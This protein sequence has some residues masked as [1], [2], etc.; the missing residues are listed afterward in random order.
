MARMTSANMPRPSA[1]E[2]GRECPGGR[3]RR[4]RVFTRAAPRLRGE[5]GWGC[6]AGDSVCSRTA[7]ERRTRYRSRSVSRVCGS[8][9]TW[10]TLLNVHVVSPSSS[11][12]LPDVRRPVPADAQFRSPEA[13]P[14]RCTRILRPLILGAKYLGYGQCGL[15]IEFD[16][17]SFR[18]KRQ[19][20][21]GAILLVQTVGCHGLSGNMIE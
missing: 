3:G 20:R 11:P 19:G 8:P 10:F 12:S 21:N 9:V 4:R 6:G 14:P 17:L 18:Q 5:G 1:R 2:S 7:Y 13:A 15:I 16:R